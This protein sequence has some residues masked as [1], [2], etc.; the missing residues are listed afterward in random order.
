[1]HKES[2]QSAASEIKTQATRTVGLIKFW[3]TKVILY[4]KT[5]YTSF[6]KKSLEKFYPNAK[7]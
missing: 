4:A 7:K 2:L 6:G 1:M 3:Y 5:I